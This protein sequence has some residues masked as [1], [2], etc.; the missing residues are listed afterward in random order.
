ML[1]R[2]LLIYALVIPVTLLAQR[3]S[4]RG[5]NSENIKGSV[6]VIGKV[7]RP[8]KVGL[9]DGMGVYEAI[10]KAG[11]FTD[12]ANKK[13]ITITRGGE[14]YTFDAGAYIRGKNVGQ[15]IH[16]QDGDVIEVP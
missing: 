8:G 1:P 4:N 9:W 2:R 11:G 7:N 15:D 3:P 13:K 6:S 12:S 5:P 14:Q 10:V 16:L